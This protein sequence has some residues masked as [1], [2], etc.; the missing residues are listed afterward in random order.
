MKQKLF[1]F[2]FCCCISL[3]GTAQT[4][5]FINAGSRAAT[6]N[7]QELTV[8]AKG[9]G[10]YYLRQVNG[11][12]KDS[13]VISIG[14]EQLQNYLNRA[15]ATGFF[16]LNNESRGKA[17]DGTGIYISMNKN[18]KTHFVELANTDI[19]LVN[20]LIYQ[21]NNMLVPFHIR[22]NYGQFETNK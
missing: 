4:V 3:A 19:P 16:N 12:V 8:D 22:I 14:Q 20:E 15:E 1:F 18:G 21:L 17:V 5:L 9:N 7:Q 11:P 13:A 10:R 2:I 6:G